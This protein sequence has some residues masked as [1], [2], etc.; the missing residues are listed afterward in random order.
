MKKLTAIALTAA[1][2]LSLT[3][4]S[5]SE[6]ADTSSESAD[7]TETTE[8]TETETATMETTGDGVGSEYLDGFNPLDYVTLG[9]Y[10]GIEVSVAKTEVTDDDVEQYLNY[11]PTYYTETNE[12][13]DRAAV[14]GD[15]ANIDYVGTLDGVEFDGGSATG[16]DL[17]LG[18]GTFIDGFEDGVIGMEPGDVKDLELTFPEEYSNEELAGKDVIFTV[19]LNYI[20]EYI[21]PELNDEFAKSLDMG[22]DTVDDLR[23]EIRKELEDE[24]ASDYENDLYTAIESALEEKCTFAETMPTA[25]VDR[26]A[27][28]MIDSITQSAESYGVEPGLL[29][30]YYYGVDSEDYE[31]GIRDY[32]EDMAKMYI[33]LGAVGKTEGIE[34]TDEEMDQTMQDELDAAGSSYTLDEYKELLGDLE[35]YK[36]YVY[37]T[38]VMEFL[39]ENAVVNEE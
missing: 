21:T 39:A 8:T 33:M 1:M 19:T 17:T 3:A 10:K 34:I 16:Y 4:C 36:E 22:C 32:C 25:Y 26:M 6:K 11:L 12:I 14:D 38:K 30:S 5:S 35:S 29:A 2:V 27:S 13:T 24:A 37:I 31:T 28:T 15:T 18:S 20:T 9:E 23:E 7:T